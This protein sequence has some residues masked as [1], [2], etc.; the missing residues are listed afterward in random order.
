MSNAPRYLLLDTRLIQDYLGHRK[1]Q[2]TALVAVQRVDT[3][4]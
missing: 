4:L 2:H 3:A 1:I